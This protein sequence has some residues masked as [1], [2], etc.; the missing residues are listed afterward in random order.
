M[1]ITEAYRKVK[2]LPNRNV[3]LECLDLG[4]RWAFLFNDEPLVVDDC[5]IGGC[6]DAINKT[7]GKLTDIPVNSET[8]KLLSTAVPVDINQFK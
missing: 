2:K 3:L 7:T 5:L 8:F 1:N 6:Y 4:D